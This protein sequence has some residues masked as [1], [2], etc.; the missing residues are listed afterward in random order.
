MSFLAAHQRLRQRNSAAANTHRRRWASRERH[1]SI[2]GARRIS[3]TAKRNRHLTAQRFAEHLAQRLAGRV[4]QKSIR[5][6]PIAQHQGPQVIGGFKHDLE[7]VD[8]RQQPF[9]GLGQ[10][11][12]STAAAALRAVAVDARAV[13]L[14]GVATLISLLF[15]APDLPLAGRRP[16]PEVPSL[17][18]DPPSAGRRLSGHQTLGPMRDA[19]LPAR[20]KAR[21]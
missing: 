5:G 6:T 19:V 8:L 3:H 21:P 1:G 13:D 2:G 9:G 14:F 10:P 12:R 11:I 7:I 18:P 15:V 16:V 4:K 17:D 20:Q